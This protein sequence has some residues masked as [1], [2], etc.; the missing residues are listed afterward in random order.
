MKLMTT[1]EYLNL[2]RSR[3][4]LRDEHDRLTGRDA[5]RIAAKIKEIDVTLSQHEWSNPEDQ[6]KFEEQRPYFNADRLQAQIDYIDSLPFIEDNL[7]QLGPGE[8]SK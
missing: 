1:E 2:R 6:N 7:P 8:P 5:G 4:I 3:N